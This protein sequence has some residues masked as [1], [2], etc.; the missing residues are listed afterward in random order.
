MNKKPLWSEHLREVI[1]NT[2]QQWERF[3][4]RFLLCFVD[5]ATKYRVSM[6]EFLDQIQR[7]NKGAE[8]SDE[9]LAKS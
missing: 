9:C 7:C 5:L 4:G 1:D 8:R 2:N 3:F 6:Y